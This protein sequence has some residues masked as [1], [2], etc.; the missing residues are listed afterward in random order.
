VRWMISAG[1][2]KHKHKQHLKQQLRL[3]WDAIKE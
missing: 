2:D 1:K 3:V